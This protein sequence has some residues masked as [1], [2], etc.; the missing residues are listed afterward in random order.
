MNRFRRGF[1]KKK[2]LV[3][4]PDGDFLEGIESGL[5][6]DRFQVYTAKSYQ[7]AARHLAHFNPDVVVISLEL[8]GDES[9]K[10]VRALRNQDPRSPFPIFI[11]SG[12]Y[13][14]DQHEYLRCMLDGGPDLVKPFTARELSKLIQERHDRSRRLSDLHDRG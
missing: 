8:P 4:D 7:R 3:V 6:R 2:V 10:L 5:R 1:R 14:V 11:V 9:D 12:R 13:I